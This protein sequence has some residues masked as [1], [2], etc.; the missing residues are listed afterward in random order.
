MF[1][2]NLT[3]LLSMHIW[4]LFWQTEGLVPNPHNTSHFTHY[5][6]ELQS[7]KCFEGH[8]KCPQNLS[9]QHRA[10][11]SMNCRLQEPF[12]GLRAF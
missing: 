12:N 11:Y 1:S 2:G 6:L 4:S 7:A 3:S 9:T 8:N 5:F 10:F